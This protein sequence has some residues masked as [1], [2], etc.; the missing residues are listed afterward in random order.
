MGALGFRNAV[1]EHAPRTVPSRPFA[2]IDAPSTLLDQT[3]AGVREG[4]MRTVAVS[5]R[6]DP[7]ISG[8]AR[9]GGTDGH[10]R[11]AQA[12]TERHQTAK[13]EID[14][15]RVRVIAIE[16]EEHRTGAQGRDSWELPHAVKSGIITVALLYRPYK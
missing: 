1:R 8:E 9:D 12:F 16:R 15:A 2:S 6:D 11:D 13:P 14:A 5:A 3:P 4:V 7:T 10:L